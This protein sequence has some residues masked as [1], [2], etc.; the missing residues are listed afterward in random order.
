MKETSPK[1]WLRKVKNKKSLDWLDRSLDHM[2][3]AAGKIPGSNTRAS[4]WLFNTTSNR[5]TL[6]EQLGRFEEAIRDWE[7]V[8]KLATAE[9]QSVVRLKRALCLAQNGEPEKAVVE[10]DTVL[11]ESGADGAHLLFAARI[12]AQAA[13]T[14]ASAKDEYAKRSLDLLQSAQ[15]AGAFA[16]DE[17]IKS[18]KQDPHLEP[19]RSRPDFQNWL[20]ELE[21]KKR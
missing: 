13:S 7:M 5:A 20:G 3:E 19:L 10:V 2:R 21:L 14:T 8:L 17:E 4:N 16:S 15:H 12:L 1:P 18:L 9:Q 6:L 11:S